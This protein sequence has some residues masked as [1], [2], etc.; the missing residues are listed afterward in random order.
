[1]KIIPSVPT[2][3][4]N[5]C[6]VAACGAAERIEFDSNRWIS[7]CELTVCY[8]RWMQWWRNDAGNN[9]LALQ[10]SYA[11]YFATIKGCLILLDGLILLHECC[12]ENTPV[13]QAHVDY[14]GK[15]FS[16]S[17]VAWS[18][19][20]AGLYV[21]YKYWSTYLVFTEVTGLVPSSF[22]QKW[23][24][25]RWEC[26][27]NFFQKSFQQI[28]VNLQPKLQQPK[29]QVYFPTAA[30]ALSVP[31]LLSSILFISLIGTEDLNEEDILASRH[32][33]YLY[34][35]ICL[36]VWLELLTGRDQ[37]GCFILIHTPM[38]R[39]ALFVIL[40]PASNS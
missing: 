20:G 10:K 36:R 7:R 25:F 38:G 15:S 13:W 39:L 29:W 8:H 21:S 27:T 12:F 28:T 1:M 37:T 17:P 22:L 6:S 24:C 33:I 14:P 18:G 16:F 2:H 32:A 4:L 30:F 26:E 23:H 3:A 19:R 34:S 9:L 31:S 11:L 40:H 35:P 5:L